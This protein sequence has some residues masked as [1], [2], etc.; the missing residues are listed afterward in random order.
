MRFL[1]FIFLCHRGFPFVFI[2][3]RLDYLTIQIELI[4]HYNL[5]SLSVPLTFHVEMKIEGDYRWEFEIPIQAVE[6]TAA[7]SGTGTG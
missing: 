7:Y 4:P 2:W 5:M 6:T 1:C 3:S